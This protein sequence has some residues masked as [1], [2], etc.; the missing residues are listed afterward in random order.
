MIKI[1]LI[2]LSLYPAAWIGSAFKI[3]SVMVIDRLWYQAK[4]FFMAWIVISVFIL[5]KFN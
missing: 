2:L 4:H 3:N 5:L 1:A